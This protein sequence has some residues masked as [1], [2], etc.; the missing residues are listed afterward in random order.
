MADC[1]SSSTTTT[2]TKTVQPTIQLQKP[3]PAAKAS[4]SPT[5]ADTNY[6]E[7][8]ATEALRL[9]SATLEALVHATG[10]IPP[11]P[12][13][14]SPT[15]PQMSGLQAEKD[16][17]A[18]SQRRTSPVSPGRRSS[19]SNYNTQ[20]PLSRQNG[21]SSALRQMQQPE[22]DGVRLKPSKEDCVIIEADSGPLNAQHSAITRKFYSKLEPPISIT[23]YL[24][25]LHQ[26]CPMST[27]VY[28]ATSLYIHRLAVEQGAV[29]VTRRNVHRLVLAG[30]RVATKALED[31]AYPHSKV[32]KVGGVSEAELARLEISFCFLAGFELVVGNEMLKAHYEA[33]KEEQRRQHQSG[34]EE[35][36][37]EL[38]VGKT[39]TQQTTA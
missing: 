18:R 37:L 2:Q 36:V 32:S 15:H 12:P 27:A 20:D 3:T 23:Q 29:H 39:A 9:L 28:I 35:T 21:G 8:A 16:K 19:A 10:D 11:T 26:F 7:L 17:L 1:A 6:S 13:P 14:K 24:L 38:R 5:S 31:L 34:P 33:M 22:V 25:R 4:T 30:L